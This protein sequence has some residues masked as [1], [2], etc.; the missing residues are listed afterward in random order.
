MRK[1][2]NFN[3]KWPVQP[4]NSQLGSKSIEDAYPK[5]LL[6]AMPISHTF[7]GQQKNPLE[8]E[9]RR[10]D[11]IRTG[12]TYIKRGPPFW[13]ASP[14]LPHRRWAWVKKLAPWN[15]LTAAIRDLARCEATVKV[16]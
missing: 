16:A 7:S 10:P 11:N 3:Q 15:A 6:S 12:Q 5:I 13:P 2:P 9:M 8:S 4:T 1:E 14:P